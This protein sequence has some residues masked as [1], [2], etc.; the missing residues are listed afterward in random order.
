MPR[1][2]TV[3]QLLKAKRINNQEA[4]VLSGL[5]KGKSSNRELSVTLGLP[6]NV[7][8]PRVFSL[9]QM[10]LVQQAGTK[11]DSVTNRTVRV[12]ASC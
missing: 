1:K 5:R 12:W 3:A 8:T 2:L 11:Y 9:R 7:I 4:K 10:G 6:I